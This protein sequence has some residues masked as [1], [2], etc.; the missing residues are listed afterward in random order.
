MTLRH[1]FILASLA[2]PP[3][4]AQGHAGAFIL[5]K[6]R[7]GNAGTVTIELTVD[8]GQHPT[9]TTRQDALEAMRQVLEVDDP[10]SRIPLHSLAQPVVDAPSSPD[11]DLPITLDPAELNRGHELVRMRY[12]WQVG[13]REVRFAVPTG[14]PHDVLF[15]WADAA[16]PAGA[17]VP[18]NILIGGDL[19]PTIT[20]LE[21]HEKPK[22]G[23]TARLT[24][25]GGLAL[26]VIGALWWR[27]HRSL[28]LPPSRGEFGF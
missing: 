8:C 2:L 28:P 6:C 25:A 7:T 9:L 20:L 16:R 4:L 3:T 1:A 5:A 13:T 22:P 24:L 19:T 26:G 27:R 21:T 15:W 23:I 18:W 10:P 11:P 14:N 17:P 12:T